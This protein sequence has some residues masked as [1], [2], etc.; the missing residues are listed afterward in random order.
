M[1]VLLKKVRNGAKER[2][3]KVIAKGITSYYQ[4]FNG[5]K[6]RVGTENQPISFEFKNNIWLLGDS[7]TNGHGVDFNDTYH[8]QFNFYL[9]KKNIFFNIIPVSDVDTSF[10]D[11]KDTFDIIKN[12]VKKND[13][14][15]YQFNYNDIMK[16]VK[17]DTI[18]N[19]K[20]ILLGPDDLALKVSGE[21][22]RQIIHDVNKF[23]YKYLNYSTFF[24]FLQYHASLF[25]RKTSGSCSDRGLDA[26]GP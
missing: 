19:K 13:L 17:S 5:V 2:E 26:L 9:K 24:K 11:H 8:S 14:L 20:K 6:V 3:D 25:L 12:F 18:L 23:R 16:V 4:K 10:P 22:W 15:I 1:Q 7:V 21:K